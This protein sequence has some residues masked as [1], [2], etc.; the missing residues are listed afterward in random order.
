MMNRRKIFEIY[1]DMN[2]INK[3]KPTIK[4]LNELTEILN[5]IN[6]PDERDNDDLPLKKT[7]SSHIKEGNLHGDEQNRFQ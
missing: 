6:H 5:E 3:R 7:A 2:E 4:E 1:K